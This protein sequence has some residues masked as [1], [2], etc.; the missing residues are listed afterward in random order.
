MFKIIGDERNFPEFHQF[1]ELGKQF[2]PFAQKKLGFN[3][4]VDVELVSDPQNAKDPLGK[5]AYYDPNKMKITLFVDKRHVKDILRSL[6]HELVHHTQ[7]CRGDFNKGHDLGEGSFSTNKELQKLELEAYA[8][9]NGDVVRRFEEQYKKSREVSEMKLDEQL[10]KDEVGTVSKYEYDYD[11]IQAACRGLEKR[12]KDLERIKQPFK[13]EIWSAEVMKQYK[14]SGWMPVVG[15]EHAYQMAQ[16]AQA[17]SFRYTGL[18][19]ETVK[20]VERTIRVKDK[21]YSSDIYKSKVNPTRGIRDSGFSQGGEGDAQLQESLDNFVDSILNEINSDSYLLEQDTLKENKD[22]AKVKNAGKYTVGMEAGYDN[23]GDGVP[24]GGDKN[25]NNGAVSEDIEEGKGKP[26]PKCGKIHEGSC[27]T[28]ENLQEEV[29]P[30][31]PD[32][33]VG[34]KGIEY[35]EKW[36]A[37]AECIPGYSKERKCV[38][39]KEGKGCWY[40]PAKMSKRPEKGAPDVPPIKTNENWFKGNKDELLFEELVKRWTK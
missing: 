27:G 11:K 4:P 39:E 23:D 26:C 34:A 14:H 32:V 15:F 19:K 36:Y 12:D 18:K 30:D 31:C 37:K 35:K 8:K 5:T 29:D 13:G 7:N 16:C 17:K 3:K 6:S 25:P 21:E 40:P 28:H 22:M 33:A 2:V 38:E 10:S 9:G 24:N 20:G 1:Y